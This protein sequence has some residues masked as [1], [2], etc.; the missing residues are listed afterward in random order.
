MN[1]K[2]D[3]STNMFIRV[4]LLLGFLLL[5]SAC[6]IDEESKADIGEAFNPEV[7]PQDPPDDVLDTQLCYS[8]T[9]IQPD[10]EISKKI[11]LLFVVDTSG[12]LSAERA[13]I[14]E[15]IDAFIDELPA[16]VDVHVS[17]M[18]AHSSKSSYSGK[19]YA[20]SGN[21]KVLKSSELTTTDMQ[22]LL[23]ENM[24]SIKTDSHSDG[25]EVGLFS[26]I[27]G[28]TTHLVENSALDFFRAD[29]GLAVVFVA[30]ENDICSLSQYPEG[31]DPVFDPNHKEWPAHDR[32]CAGINPESVISQLQ[33]LKQEAPLL[34]SGIIYTDNETLPAT[35]ENEIGYGYLETVQ[36]SNGI[37]VDL[38]DGNYDS[39][40][41]QIGFLA[42]KKLNLLTEFPL[43][44]AD[45]D[46]STLKVLVDRQPVAFS[47][48]SVP[49]EIHIEA[50]LVGGERSEI[51][52]SYCQPLSNPVV[53]SNFQFIEPNRTSIIVEWNTD[54]ASPTQL[55]YTDVLTGEVMTTALDVNFTTYHALNIT[56]LTPDTLYN[57]RAIAF[58]DAAEP[59]YSESFPVRTLP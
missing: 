44:H 3:N 18:L 37:L 20:K 40:M 7:L 53:I 32:D 36:Q 14:A 17:V 4:F 35:G 16:D 52:I 39:S 12:S 38:A 2:L 25:G 6:V 50:A 28:V 8:D 31:V 49:N 58:N 29:A 5:T 45:F 47:Y 24:T 22:T 13:G 42:V 43:S 23:R 21:P 59:F 55:E 11:D 19:L 30:D 26:L 51:Y 33:D 34:L 1:N 27:E 41:Q 56:D 57:F 10:A 54:I 48:Q 46:Q 15:G 9:F